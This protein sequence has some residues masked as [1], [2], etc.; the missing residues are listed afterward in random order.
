MTESC[1]EWE[2][3][4]LP[5]LCI[6]VQNRQFKSETPGGRKFFPQGLQKRLLLDLATI[7]H[8]LHL[9]VLSRDMI[10]STYIHYIPIFQIHRQ[11]RQLVNIFF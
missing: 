9:F 4:S 7:P 2:T 3:L 6:S 11:K 8:P 1:N 10:G 5:A